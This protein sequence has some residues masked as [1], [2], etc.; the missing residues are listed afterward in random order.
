MT[1]RPEDQ[2][3]PSQGPRLGRTAQP[4]RTTD[5][6]H[7]IV[8][9]A[10]RLDWDIDDVDRFA[11]QV[12]HVEYGLSAENEFAAVLRWLG[13]C[14]FVHRLSEVALEDEARSQ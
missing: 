9:A 12:Q 7:A 1:D 8:K 6:A 13:W 5:A 4:F 3:S 10:E 11:R 2:S 14:S